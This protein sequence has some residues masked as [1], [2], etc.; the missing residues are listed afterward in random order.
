MHITRLINNIAKRV[1]TLLTIPFKI[2]KRAGIFRYFQVI[3]HSHIRLF[4]KSAPNMVKYLGQEEAI[5]IDQELF[6]EY[7]YSVDQLMELAGLSC[8][9]AIAKLYSKESF[10]GK[11]ILVCCGPGNNGGDGLV[12]SRHLKLFGYKPVVYYPTKTDKPLYNTLIHQC[13]CMGITI[14]KCLPEESTIDSQFGL[15]VD[16]LFGFSFKP[17]VRETFVPI[18]NL[19]KNTKIP[20]ASIDIPSGWDVEQ[21]EPE[22]GGIKPELLISLTAPK[23]CAKKFDG[24]AHYLG[25]RFIPPRLEEKYALDL[26][27]YPGTDCVV[28][29]K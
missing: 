13:E 23:K 17:P 24:L 19:M 22:E 26:P 15:L 6:N 7:Q 10:S 16:A 25:G 28:M 2:F 1:L 20:I 21:G 14:L 29:L 4:T 11:Y 3:L 8:A 12:C 5:N 27:Q 18:I 9:T